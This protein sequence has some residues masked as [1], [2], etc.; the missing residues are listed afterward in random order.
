MTDALRALL[1]TG[2]ASALVA[3]GGAPDDSA[4]DPA[5]DDAPAASVDA[6]ERLSLADAV[7][8]ERRADDADR[9]RFRNPQQTLEFFE[10]GPGQRV[11]EIWPGYYTPILAPYLA[12]NNGTYVAVLYPEGLT[13]GLDRRVSAFREQYADADTFGTIEYGSFLGGEINGVAV[14]PVINGVADNSVDRVISRRNIHS[15]MGRDMADDAF[16]ESYRILK[17]GG[18]MG[19][20]AHRLPETRTQDPKAATGYVQESYIKALAADAGFEF[21][22]ASEIN[23]NPLDTADHPFGVWTLPP[24]SRLPDEGSVQAQDF[25]AEAYRNIGESDR[26]TL[27]FRKPA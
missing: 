16:A 21:V 1:L 15:W 26:A 27:L 12:D 24:S 5:V 23:A 2:A 25:D 9:D 14:E 18:M 22:G 11:A 8:D 6:G 3:C 20:V 19:V 4:A 17:P 13:E 10:V 7:A